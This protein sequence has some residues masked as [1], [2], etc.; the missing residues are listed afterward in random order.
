MNAKR[1][2]PDESLNH[3]DEMPR[4][5]SGNDG[6]P[7]LPC[8]AAVVVDQLELF[9]LGLEKALRD[10]SVDV[11]AAS[12]GLAEGLRLVTDRSADLLI[13]GKHP[14]L[15]RK[16]A[17]KAIKKDYPTLRIVVLVEQAELPDLAM[18]IDSG[19]DALLLRSAKISEFYEAVQ[20]VNAGERF[21]ASALAVG[22]IGRVGPLWG[23]E[24]SSEPVPRTVDDGNDTTLPHPLSAREL[25]VLAELS[26]GATYDE[27]A[28]SLIVT[29]AT[30]KTHLVH[31]Y[32]KLDVRNRHEAIARALALGILG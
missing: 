17:L 26:T 22:T 20:R 12:T 5:E 27:I 2:L 13:V 28:A 16:K 23:S 1:P 18:L 31:I 24:T 14:D 3:A 8:A 15:K 19:V 32:D 25:D 30:V 11:V 7:A 10:C 29:R 9:R 4:A 21:V 6:L